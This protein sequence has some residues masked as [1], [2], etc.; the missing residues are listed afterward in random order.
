MIKTSLTLAPALGG[1]GEGR[2][3]NNKGGETMTKNEIIKE[4][5]RLS[6]GDWTMNTS[7]AIAEAIDIIKMYEGD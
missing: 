3:I 7:E 1:L 5:E 4:L 2:K 6:E